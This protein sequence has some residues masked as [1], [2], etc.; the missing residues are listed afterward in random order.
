MTVVEKKED[1]AV[2]RA[3]K[4][5]KI[6]HN[7]DDGR[8][9]GGQL[10]LSIRYDGRALQV[11][12]HSAKNLFGKRSQDPYAQVYLVEGHRYNASNPE[13]RTW[14]QLNNEKTEVRDKT[15]N[16]TWDRN[17][18]FEKSLEWLRD[19]SLAIA[20]WDQDSKSRDDYMS[21]IRISLEDLAYFSI[22]GMVTVELQH[23]ELDGHPAQPSG[24]WWRT[25]FGYTYRSGAWDLKTCNNHLVTFIE[26]A[27]VLAEAYEVKKMYPDHLNDKTSVS[28]SIGNLMGDELEKIRMMLDGKKREV[29]Q[30]RSQRD[31]LKSENITLQRKYQQMKVDLQEN[32]SIRCGL[33]LGRMYEKT[34]YREREVI[35]AEVPHFRGDN[36]RYQ[37]FLQRIIKIR[38]EYDEKIKLELGKVRQTYTVKYQDFISSIQVSADEIMRLYED[39]IRERAAKNP[40]YRN[41]LMGLESK[42]QYHVRI[43]GL[44]KDIARL[45]DSIRA[46][47]ERLARLDGDWMA[48]IN[49]I[50]AELAALMGRI[51]DVMHKMRSYAEGKYTVTNEISIFDKLLSFEEQRLS[52][53]QSQ[54]SVR[55]ST[56]TNRGRH[57]SVPRPSGSSSYMEQHYSESTMRTSGGMS[58]GFRDRESGYSETRTRSSRT[59]RSSTTSTITNGMPRD[60]FLQSLENQMI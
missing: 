46:L 48:R 57:H 23:Q 11:H 18:T 24:T 60:N 37:D 32:C 33:E 59:S 36:T 14:F 55:V 29:E 5:T 7:F 34:V 49:A 10:T 20:I 52:S 22:H 27:R 17:F 30:R 15:L 45:D 19:K 31:S 4:G 21:G 28:G 41:G 43:E 51:R 2:A 1:N 47:M 35:P 56:T 16:P 8:A 50:D 9:S 39:I 40:D 12:V 53:H 44:R 54:R 25:F 6:V 13:P 26:K 3:R 38:T 58:P 42:R